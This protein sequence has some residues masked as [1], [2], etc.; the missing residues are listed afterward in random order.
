MAQKSNAVSKFLRKK[1]KKRQY[2]L[3]SHFIGGTAAVKKQESFK[4]I[5]LSKK[6][7]SFPLCKRRLSKVCTLPSL[8]HLTF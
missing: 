3:G 1:K 7:E 5:F 2:F 4:H 6:F 8:A